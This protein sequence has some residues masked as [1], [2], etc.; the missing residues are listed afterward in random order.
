MGLGAFGTVY[1]SKLLGL[2]SAP[3]KLRVLD[4]LRSFCKEVGILACLSPPN[5]IKYFRCGISE[6]KELHLEMSD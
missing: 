4:D 5:L 1:E 2:P 3:K 6:H